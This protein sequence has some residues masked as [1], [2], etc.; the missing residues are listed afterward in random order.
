MHFRTGMNDLMSIALLV[1]AG[2]CVG[3]SEP[4]NP[5][6][7][8]PEGAL[9][10]A[11]IVVTEWSERLP[12]ADDL[13]LEDLPPIR[14]FEGEC[15]DYGEADCPT[16]AT[17]FAWNGEEEIHVLVRP[18]IHESSLAHEILHWSLDVVAGSPDGDHAGAVWAQVSEVDD[19]LRR[20]G[21]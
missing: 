7:A 15:L 13:I 20:A 10:A 16:G 5:E 8:P 11:A 14:W 21:L 3:L 1:V 9:D 4:S 17:I 2:G 19:I 18:T 6:V 12:G